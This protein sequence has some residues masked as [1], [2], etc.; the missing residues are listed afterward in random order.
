MLREVAVSKW[1]ETQK[2][3]LGI[4][5]GHHDQLISPHLL[6]T[7]VTTQRKAT[8]SPLIVMS[9][10]KLVALTLQKRIELVKEFE[11]TRPS[12]SALAKKYGLS[13]S[14]VCRILKRI[15]HFFVN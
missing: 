10:K 12:Q 5:C 8:L 7:E 3:P 11:S 1:H 15:I 4:K 9:T 14:S 2:Q 6:C 13:E